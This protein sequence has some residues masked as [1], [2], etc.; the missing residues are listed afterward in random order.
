MFCNFRQSFINYSH[1][2]GRSRHSSVCIVTRL[3]IGQRRNRGYIPGSTESSIFLFQ[4]VQTL[5]GYQCCFLWRCSP[6]R[7]RT[8][9]FTR[10][11]DHTQRRTTVSMSP[12][13]EWSVRR[14]D[15]YLAIHNTQN[16]DIHAPGG[17]RTH[18]R[19]RRLLRSSPDT[20]SSSSVIIT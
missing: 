4:I 13:D 16:R 12:L 17:I 20:R 18:D 15:L 5:N 8:S 10:F 11:P 3:K 6:T 1:I 9:L 7:A 19:R 2:F 14:R